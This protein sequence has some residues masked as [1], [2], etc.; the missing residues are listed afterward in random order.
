MHQP[1]ISTA[2]TARMRDNIA[3]TALLQS[4]QTMREI[5]TQIT[6]RSTM[7]VTM[8]SCTQEYMQI[9][10]R[11]NTSTWDKARNYSCSLLYNT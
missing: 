9:S 4:V 2:I 11:T 3:L 6:M 8:V 10:K 5:S 1:T 7:A